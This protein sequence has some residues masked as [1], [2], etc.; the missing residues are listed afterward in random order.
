M[1]THFGFKSVE[2]CP[3]LLSLRIINLAVATVADFA[4]PPS[5]ASSTLCFG[6]SQMLGQLVKINPFCRCYKILIL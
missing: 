5:S 2:L 6:Q 1:A 3:L 4:S